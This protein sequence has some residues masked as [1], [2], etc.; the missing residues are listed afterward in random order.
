M[1]TSP[2]T[3]ELP[4]SSKVIPCAKCGAE[5]LTGKYTVMVFCRDCSAQM[6]VKK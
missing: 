1:S 3:I 6:G 4:V 2:K 5:V